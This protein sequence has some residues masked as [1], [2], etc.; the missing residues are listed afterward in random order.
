MLLMN[1][2]EMVFNLF[3]AYEAGFLH[4]WQTDTELDKAAL[5][6]PGLRF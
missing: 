1:L 4:Y 3:L 2:A 6:Q 5:F